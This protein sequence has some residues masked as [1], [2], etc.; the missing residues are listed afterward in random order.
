M[1][2]RSGRRIRRGLGGLGGLVLAASAGAAELRAVDTFDGVAQA[3]AAATPAQAEALRAVAYEPGAFAVR[4]EDAGRGSRPRAELFFPAPEPAAGRGDRAAPVRVSWWEA[5]GA[6]ERG[7]APRPAVLVVHSLAPGQPLARG[8]ASAVAAAGVDAFVVDLPGYGA[9]PPLPGRSPGAEAVLS[10][11]GG[12]A[13]A[14]RALD[15]VAALPGV[16]GDRVVIAGVSLG[17]FAASA[18]AGLDD[19]PAALVSF[20]GGGSAYEALRDGA[21]DAGFLRDELLR[22][23]ETMDSLR[24][25][26]RP[27]EPLT[28]AGRLDPA[29][30][31]VA[32]AAADRVIPPANTEAFVRAVGGVGLAEDHWIRRPGN[33][34]TA[35]FAL[36]GVAQLLVELAGDARADR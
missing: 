22:G 23:G 26:L 19:R 10:G 25:L 1:K 14:R 15:A 8:L 36:P 12:V 17:S 30:V 28:L 6:Q 35:G 7:D 2:R 9:R 13:D 11:A 24:A 29:R 16:D 18:V 32:S 21:K 3:A 31:W 4:V 33:H 20:L 5:A 34:Y 27:V